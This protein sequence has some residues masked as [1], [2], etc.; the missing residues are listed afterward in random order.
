VHCRANP[1]RAVAARFAATQPPK[2][3]AIKAFPFSFQR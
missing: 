1:P 2:P 3:P